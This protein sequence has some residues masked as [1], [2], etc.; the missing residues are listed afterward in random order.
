M[1]LLKRRDSLSA[2]E[3]ADWWLGSHAPLAKALPGLRGA[4]FNL[5]D[6]PSAS[7]DGISELWF[8]SREAFEAAYAT[9]HGKSVAAD[10]A[11][12]VSK[13]ERLYVQEH[14]LLDGAN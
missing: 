10:S 4:R 6:D 7:V 1:I 13:R 11:A 12:H 5:V 9:E 8:D 3:F 2:K 14:V